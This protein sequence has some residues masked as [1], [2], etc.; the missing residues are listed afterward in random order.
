MGCGSVG[1]TQPADGSS[2]FDAAGTCRWHMPLACGLVVAAA[3]YLLSTSSE[4]RTLHR[5]SEFRTLQAR[6]EDLEAKGKGK[7]SSSTEADPAA[8]LTARYEDQIRELTERAQTAEEKLS[9]QDA[10][11]AKLQ[12]KVRRGSR[13]RGWWWRRWR[14]R[15]RRW[16]GRWWR[17]WSG[18]GSGSRW[19]ERWWRRS[20]RGS[21]TAPARAVCGVGIV[22]RALHLLSAALAKNITIGT[23]GLCSSTAS[24]GPTHHLTPV[25]CLTS[26]NLLI[27]PPH[28][29]FAPHLPMLLGHTRA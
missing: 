24:P 12:A 25:N 23:L 18:S 3:A 19:R 13:W 7:R 6:I 1:H 22:V 20:W 2:L 4:F 21:H 29:P 15:R 5:S 26:A 9:G 8:A 14:G 27:P 17:R 10:S 28:L 11:L 16:R